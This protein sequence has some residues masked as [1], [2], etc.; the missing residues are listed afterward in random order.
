ME[1]KEGSI[2]YLSAFV[3]ICLAGLLLAFSFS[4]KELRQY[5]A[6][7]RDGLDSACLSAALIDINAYP[8]GRVI[9]INGYD[10]SWNVFKKCLKNNM[11]LDD[12]FNLRGEGIY[13]KVTIHKFIIYNISGGRLISRSILQDGSADYENM[14]YTGRETTPDGTVIVSS[15]IYADIGMNVKS[16]LGIKKYVHVRTSVDVVNN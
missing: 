14:A 10:N 5:E 16:F 7:A 15:T 12:D 9:N 1:H 6:D 3:L 8:D 2:E 11:S 13:D 4:V